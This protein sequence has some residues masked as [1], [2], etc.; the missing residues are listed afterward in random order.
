MRLWS[1]AAVV[2]VAGAG[3]VTAEDLE[4]EAFDATGRVVFNEISTAAAY[5]V[6]WAPTPGGPWRL[7]EQI[8]A[9]G[10]GTVT[11]AVPMAYRVVATTTPPVPDDMALIPAGS[12]AMGN[13]FSEG[14]SDESPVHTV[15]VST[16]HID[17]FEVTKTRWDEVAAWGAGHGY[18]LIP[19][20]GALGKALDHPVHTVSWYECVKWCNARSEKEGRRPA[21]YTSSAKTEIYRTGVLSLRSDWVRWDSGYRL[22]T[23]AEWEKA[24]RG[25]LGGQRFPWGGTIQHTRANYY[26]SSDCSYDTSATRGYHPGYHDGVL[27]YT[28]PAG[29]FAANGYGLHTVAGNV[30]EWCWDRYASTYYA[31][32]P[33]TDPRGPASG[34]ERVSRDGSYADPAVGCR[35]ARRG[36][37]APGLVTNTVGFRTVLPA[38]EP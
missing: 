38:D 29:V 20:A 9:A 33:A 32:S 1:M 28:A 25:G 19:S 2:L 23:E 30:R 6:E 10:S 21:Y 26:S 3:R 17:P 35:V 18:D 16:F 11:A 7:L 12:F 8:P 4:V 24:A 13:S 31:V 27:P 36:G 34:S 22:P 15:Y 37:L 5:R 14:A